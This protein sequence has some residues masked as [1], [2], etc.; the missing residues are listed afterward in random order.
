MVINHKLLFVAIL[1]VMTVIISGCINH[2]I[3][4]DSPSKSEIIEIRG[5][6]FQPSSLTVSAGTTIEWVNQDGS[7]HTVTSNSGAFE[8]GYLGSGGKFNYTFKKEGVYP[9]H[10]RMHNSEMG[11][12]VVVS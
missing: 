1:I 8:S 2:G 6:S 9:Y 12:I 5:F 11:E 4:K 10:C 7:R 3:Y